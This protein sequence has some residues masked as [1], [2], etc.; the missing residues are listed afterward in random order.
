MIMDRICRWLQVGEDTFA[1]E[2][3]RPIAPPMSG[4]LALI[5]EPRVVRWT[6]RQYMLREIDRMD[7][8]SG[9]GSG[10]EGRQGNLGTDSQGTLR[11]VS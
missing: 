1:R 11:G 10:R 3:V 4:Q 9:G 2:M 8:G 7:N 5:V 6:C